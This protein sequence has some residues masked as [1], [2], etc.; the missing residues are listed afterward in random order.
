VDSRAAAQRWAATWESSWRELNVESIVALYAPDAV[1]RSHPHREPEIG[2]ARGYVTRTF[3]EEVNVECR[4]EEPIVDGARATVEWWA[5]F[6]EA[7]DPVTL[8]GVTVLLFDA[9]GLVVRHQDYWAQLT[10]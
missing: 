7:G 5:T 3:G 1:Y 6:V 8:S 2:G 4:F 10:R 9:D